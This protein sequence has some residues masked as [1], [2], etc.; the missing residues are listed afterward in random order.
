VRH[1]ASN[2]LKFGHPDLTLKGA[3]RL[4]QSNKNNVMHLYLFFLLFLSLEKLRSN[5]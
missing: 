5:F 3:L 1:P 4:K 2:Y